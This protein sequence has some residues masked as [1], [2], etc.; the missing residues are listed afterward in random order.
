M[1]ERMAGGE[2]P[3]YRERAI[4]SAFLSRGDITSTKGVWH[5]VYSER[6]LG[7][8][9]PKVAQEIANRRCV[10]RCWIFVA[11]IASGVLAYRSPGGLESD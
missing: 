10:C 1:I 5:R 11:L 9:K 8:G 3:F 2:S 7:A 4:L 6:I